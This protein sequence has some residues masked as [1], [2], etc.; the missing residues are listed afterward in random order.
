[1]STQ[2]AVLTT[3]IAEDNAIT[4]GRVD[5]FTNI[6]GSRPRVSADPDLVARKCSPPSLE[7]NWVPPG[8][9]CRKPLLE[10]S[11]SI[12]DLGT[13]SMCAEDGT[14]RLNRAR[15]HALLQRCE[16][17]GRRLLKFRHQR[18]ATDA[19]FGFGLYVPA[20]CPL[21]H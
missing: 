10:R 9:H 6:I 17:R 15:H 4:A 12:Q 1:M 16:E 5:L 18:F 13:G 14:P 7:Q 2:N 21:V 19:A 3:G 11:I 8:Q 20:L